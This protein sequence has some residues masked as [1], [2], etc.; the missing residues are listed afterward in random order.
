MVENQFYN[1][2]YSL[3]KQSISKAK[4]LGTTE[5]FGREYAIFQGTYQKQLAKEEITRKTYFLKRIVHDH[6]IVTFKYELSK[7]KRYIPVDLISSF[8]KSSFDIERTWTEKWYP[9]SSDF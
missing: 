5:V 7:E 4:F 2:S 9:Q 6:Y 3:G 8:T 1:V